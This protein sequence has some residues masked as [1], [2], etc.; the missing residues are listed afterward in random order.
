MQIYANV[1]GRPLRVA[2]SGLASALGAAML[3]A[4]AAGA[5]DG[6]YDNLAAAAAHMGGLRD[7]VYTPI[8]TEQHVYDE[9]F[10]EWKRLH[11]W[12]GRGG[13]DVMNRLR[14]LRE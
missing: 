5:G 9:L 3:G 4:V 11:E 12:F 2:R 14:R 13:S 1:I 10:A 6:G 7:H 8:P